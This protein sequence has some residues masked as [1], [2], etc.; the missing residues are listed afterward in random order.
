MLR[1]AEPSER[2]TA[3]HKQRIRREDRYHYFCVHLPVS[4]ICANYLELSEML[5]LHKYRLKLPNLGVPTSGVARR[6]WRS[7]CYPPI[8]CQDGARV[9]YKIDDKIYGGGG[10]IASLQKSF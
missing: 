1:N 8:F 10:I 6:V 9:F 7:T 2:S 3:Q 5:D 4:D